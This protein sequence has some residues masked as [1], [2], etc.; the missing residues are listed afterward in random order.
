MLALLA[1]ASCAAP[2]PLGT[3][4]APPNQDVSRRVSECGFRVVLSGW[5]AAPDATGDAVLDA[6]AAIA[7]R[8]GSVTVG[9][10][11]G[12]HE[13][14]ND[15]QAL[16]AIARRHGERVRDL[17]IARGVVPEPMPAIVLV[18]HPEASSSGAYIGVCA[19]GRNV[20]NGWRERPVDPQHLVRTRIGGRSGATVLAVPILNFGP[21]T[22]NDIPLADNFITQFRFD[23]ADD[24]ESFADLQYRC[25]QLS[26]ADPVCARRQVPVQV[27]SWTPPPNR[28]PEGETAQIVG[29]VRSDV[30]AGPGDRRLYLLRRWP[31]DASSSGNLTCRFANPAQGSRTEGPA[32]DQL[33]CGGALFMQRQRLAVSILGFQADNEAEAVAIL[34][35]VRRDMVR[36]VRDGA[37]SQGGPPS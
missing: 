11:Y 28:V 17:L 12:P 36:F 8:T 37:A 22:W 33:S 27:Q 18:S 21:Y 24:P 1:G 7:R 19:R 2:G 14:V 13:Q 6:A 16:N 25:W 15:F 29:L 26:G 9:G 30:R 20:E 35:R 5:L 32:H 10:T 3:A 31:G 34:D 4:G 23:R